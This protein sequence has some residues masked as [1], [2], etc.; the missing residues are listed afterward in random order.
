MQIPEQDSIRMVL[1]KPCVKVMLLCFTRSFPFYS[2]GFKRHFFL[3]LFIFSVTVT[4]HN[5]RNRV[6]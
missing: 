2:K 6:L 5:P 3:L 4:E 1:T